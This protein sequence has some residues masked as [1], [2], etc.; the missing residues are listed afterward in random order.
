MKLSLKFIALPIFLSL[1]Q[2]IQA[3]D[4][5]IKNFSGMEINHVRVS[6]PEVFAEGNS[7]T[8]HLENLNDGEYC[9]PL[10]GAKV[11]SGYGARRGHSGA[12]IKTCANDTIRCTFDGVVRMSK[13]YG[14]Y[15]NVIVVRHANGLESLYSHNSKNFVKSGDVVKAGQA[16]ALTGR[17]GSATTEHLHF[18][19]RIDGKHFNPNV[20]FDLSDRSL[21][22]RAIVCTK[23]GRG[24]MVK[25]VSMN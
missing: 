6:D 10:P 24:V 3:G 8:I 11:I 14:G 17:T 23:K 13:K 25:P 4:P 22:K 16:I 12:D 2:F 7:V 18:E 9:F 5:P 15:G 1:S 21:R 20:I 19:F